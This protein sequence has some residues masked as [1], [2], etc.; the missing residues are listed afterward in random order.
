MIG[1]D[2]AKIRCFSDIKGGEIRFF[3]GVFRL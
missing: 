2:D 3:R 1:F